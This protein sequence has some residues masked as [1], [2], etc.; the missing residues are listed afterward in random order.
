MKSRAFENK[1]FKAYS[2]EDAQKFGF[3]SNLQPEDEYGI[4]P[5]KPTFPG[6]ALYTPNP[7]YSERQNWVGALVQIIP[8]NDNIVC[9]KMTTVQGNEASIEMICSSND[10]VTPVMFTLA[11]FFQEN[12]MFTVSDG[13]TTLVKLILQGRSY[14]HLPGTTD[15]QEVLLA[16]TGLNTSCVSDMAKRPASG[17]RYKITIARMSDDPGSFLRTFDDRDIINLMTLNTASPVNPP[18]FRADRYNQSEQ[19][20]LDVNRSYGTSKKMTTFCSGLVTDGPG[21]DVPDCSMPPLLRDCPTGNDTTSCASVV[22]NMKVGVGKYRGSTFDP[23]ASYSVDI[24]FVRSLTDSFV[25]K[26]IL[27]RGSSMFFCPHGTHHLSNLLDLVSAVEKM[28][29]DCVADDARKFVCLKKLTHMLRE[30][31]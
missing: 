8:T 4:R 19:L 17:S 26:L 16:D 31:K 25:P 11:N 22:S 14:T 2:H 24:H 21:E 3:I 23:M 1:Y 28:G 9:S 13:K 15:G 30:A 12:T 5:A 29:C 27:C 18:T 10:F 6:V 20:K 7:P